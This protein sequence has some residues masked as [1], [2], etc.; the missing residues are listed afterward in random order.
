MRHATQ[1]DSGA[2]K[3]KVAG[4]GGLF[5]LLSSQETRAG[6]AKTTLHVRA[7]HASAARSEHGREKKVAGATI[8]MPD[9]H[10]SR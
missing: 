4:I 10:T 3:T 8:A 7:R 9:V 1:R 6:G 2:T 5:G